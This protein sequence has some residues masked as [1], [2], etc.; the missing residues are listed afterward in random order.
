MP[1]SYSKKFDKEDEGDEEEENISNLKDKELADINLLMDSENKSSKKKSYG[2]VFGLIQ[3]ASYMSSYILIVQIRSFIPKLCSI[4][5][6]TRR[7]ATTCT[8]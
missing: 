8:L 6:L 4:S 3:K 7:I 5:Y 1:K 2:F